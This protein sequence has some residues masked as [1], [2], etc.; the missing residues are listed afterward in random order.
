MQV[1]PCNPRN[2]RRSVVYVPRERRVN[3]GVLTQ[4]FRVHNVHSCE[5]RNIFVIGVEKRLKLVKLHSLVS[6]F[7]RQRFV[8]ISSCNDIVVMPRDNP[9][10]SSEIMFRFFG[11]FC[12][13][14]ENYRRPMCAEVTNLHAQ[15][16]VF[17][18][19]TNKAMLVLML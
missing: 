9:E 2:L 3:V 4:R 6:R 12:E 8:S 13:A 16:V 11:R 5:S 7:T 15:A 14:R 18:L 17:R 19:R 10:T 1:N